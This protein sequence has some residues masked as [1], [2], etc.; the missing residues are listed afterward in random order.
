M[1][2]RSSENRSRLSRS[3]ADHESPVNGAHGCGASPETPDANSHGVPGTVNASFRSGRI[4]AALLQTS[5]VCGSGTPERVVATKT[6]EAGSELVDAEPVRLPTLRQAARR[7]A[8]HVLDGVL[9]PL[10]LFLVGY[11]VGGLGMAMAGG[12]GW[13]G[14]AI[15]RRIAKSRRVPAMAILGT[16]ML[17][18]RS[19]LALATGSAF[20][21]FLQPTIG[22]AVVGLAFLCSVPAGRPLSRRFAADF[23]TLPS[24]LFL[25]SYVHRFFV[26]NSMMWA[27][28]GLLNAAIA[29]CLLITLATTIFAVTQTILSVFVTVLAVGI[30]MLWFRNSICRYRPV[31]VGV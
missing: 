1:A 12:L 30:S 29:Y 14:F 3:P 4:G 7:A 6:I 26:R 16:A 8:P 13:S 27:V 9:L 19:A 11:R 25:A 20:L 24:D 18:V 22:T 17:I 23:V 10:A 2:F 28:V 15:L 21:Y 5:A 31:T